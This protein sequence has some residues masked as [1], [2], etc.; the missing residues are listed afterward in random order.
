[1][2]DIF[3]CERFKIQAVGNRIVRAYCFWVV[4]NDNSFKTFFL[5]RFSRMNRTIIKFNSLPNTNWTGT[6]NKDLFL[7]CDFYLI[8]AMPSGI[9]VR[10]NGIKFGGTSIYHFVARL[11]P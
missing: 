10:C 3:S 7:I 9:I 8:A 4:I 2:Q 1:M 5:E 11:P 6:Y